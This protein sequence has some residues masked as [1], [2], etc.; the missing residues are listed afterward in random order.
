MKP[1]IIIRS[2]KQGDTARVKVET[3]GTGPDVFVEFVATRDGDYLVSAQGLPVIVMDD[4]QKTR[5]V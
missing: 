1:D 4:E 3:G 2:M 5:T